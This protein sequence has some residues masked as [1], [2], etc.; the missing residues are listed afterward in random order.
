MELGFPANKLIAGFT[1]TGKKQIMLDYQ[2]DNGYGAWVAK[3]KTRAMEE[4][5]RPY[6]GF[7]SQ[8]EVSIFSIIEQ[9]NNL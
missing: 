9:N 6:G 4:G 2:K 3:S 1:T 8:V 7:I 5:G